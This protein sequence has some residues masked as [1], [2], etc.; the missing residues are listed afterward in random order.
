MNVHLL[1]DRMRPDDRLALVGV[2]LLTVCIGGFTRRIQGPVRGHAI[3][4]IEPGLHGIARACMIKHDVDGLREHA[5]VVEGCVNVGILT[6]DRKQ[7]NLGRVLTPAF[8]IMAQ[9]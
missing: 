2:V 1:P 6:L 3:S 5:T 9:D 8:P 7:G 4:P